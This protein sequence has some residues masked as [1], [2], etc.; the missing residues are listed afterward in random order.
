MQQNTSFPVVFEA[1][2]S[3]FMKLRT[4]VVCRWAP[5]AGINGCETLSGCRTTSPHPLK[6]SL[7]IRRH[8]HWESWH[9]QSRQRG[10]CVRHQ[11][12]NL[13]ALLFTLCLIN[14]PIQYE[15]Q[16]LL[17]GA[18]GAESGC[19]PNKCTAHKTQNHINGLPEIVPGVRRVTCEAAVP[20][21][22]VS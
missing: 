13:L 22:S 19:D 2:A 14:R 20:C 6:S 12:L 15:W 10:H 1:V 11:E 18:V 5:E 3:I 21:T 9:T 8:A 17:V 4:L 16:W 7:S